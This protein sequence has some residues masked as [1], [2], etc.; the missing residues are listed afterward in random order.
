MKLNLSIQYLQPS[1][2]VLFNMHRFKKPKEKALAETM[3][4][5]AYREQGRGIHFK[6]KKVSVEWTLFFKTKVRKD[7]NNYSQ[8]WLDDA[9]KKEGIIDD[10]N[11]N[12]I[13][14]ESVSIKYD[15]KSPR[16][17]LTISDEID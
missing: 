8:K 12:V 4:H 2:N 11:C 1:L 5:L 13:V 9:L 16:T 14:K 15:K 7:L 10:D 3:F 6:G 17:E